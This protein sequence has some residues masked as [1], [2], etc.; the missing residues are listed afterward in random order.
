MS[1]EP[2]LFV[3]WDGT[4]SATAETNAVTGGLKFTW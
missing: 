3:R 1:P 2:S 4:Y